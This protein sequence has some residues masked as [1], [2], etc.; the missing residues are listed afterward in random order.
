LTSTLFPVGDRAKVDIREIARKFGLPNADKE[1]SQEI[2]F[3]PKKDYRSFIKI[4]AEDMNKPAPSLKP[5]PIKNAAGE[6]IGEHKGIA[7]YTIGQRSG[8][9]VKSQ[10][11][12][13]VSQLDAATNTLV[14]GNDSE[15][16]AA[17][18]LANDVSWIAG[19]APAPEFKALVKIR[20]KHEPA[21][22]RVRVT[23]AGLETI[24]DVPQR[25]VSPGQ[26]AVIYRW[27]E[28]VGARE[29]LGGG[30]IT[31]SVK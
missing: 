15:N 18:L 29:V 13:Y 5:G 3:V 17:G 31:T 7:Y 9:P 25:A 11:P 24:F 6:V 14:V 30:K 16:L 2:C 21:A 4:Q 27:D 22:A 12:V 10:T 26:A 1:D 23:P 20:Y 8:L 19:E 28:K